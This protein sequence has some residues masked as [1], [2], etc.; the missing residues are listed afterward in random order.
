ML[1]KSF[2]NKKIIGQGSQSPCHNIKS[3]KNDII[4]NKSKIHKNAHFIC[5]LKALFHIKTSGVLTLVAMSRQNEAQPDVEGTGALPA[6][7]L[8]QFE[9][10]ASVLSQHGVVGE[11]LATP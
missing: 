5:F 4:N 7:P 9:V 10:R 11:C 3:N 8:L 1:K 6:N 2:S